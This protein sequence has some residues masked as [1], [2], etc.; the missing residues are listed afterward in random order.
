MRGVT[1]VEHSDKRLGPDMS[2]LS[3]ALDDTQSMCGPYTGD[4]LCTQALPLACYK[5][6]ANPKPQTLAKAN[7][8]DANFVGGQVRA[9]EP[10]A[11]NRFATIG[12]ADA[13]C[14][15]KFGP[16]WRVLTYQEGGGGVVISASQIPARTRLWIDIRD[17]PRA[18]CWDRPQ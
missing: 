8:N 1:F 12:D 11:G 10:V 14:V 2:L 16:Q 13:F 15:S 6:G 7:I 5:D 9:T 17:Q 4:T 3:C 18:R